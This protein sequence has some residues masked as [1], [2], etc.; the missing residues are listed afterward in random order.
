MKITGF[1]LTMIGVGLLALAGLMNFREGRVLQSDER[2]IATV[3]D[4]MQYEYTGQVNE[5]GVQH[6]YCSVFDFQTNDGRSFTIEE[7]GTDCAEL[8]QP[9]NYQIGE[10]VELYYD[11]ADPL[12]AVQTP[13]AVRL[14]YAGAKIVLVAGALFI[15][16]GLLLFLGSSR[17]SRQAAKR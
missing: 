14:S 16:V 10:H 3:T 4:N 13:K 17:K 12:A 8:D 1:I 15:L 6:Y 2:A 7:G 11:P 9:P 5:Y